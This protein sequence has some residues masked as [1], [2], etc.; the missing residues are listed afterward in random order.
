[1]GYDHPAPR[2]EAA[3]DQLQRGPRLAYDRSIQLLAL[4]AGL[5][6]TLT[7]L[8]ILWL[9]DYTPKVQWTLSTLIVGCTLLCLSVL[10]QRIVFPFQTLSNLLA[11]L[12]EGDYSLR[13]R[14]A[15]RD[16]VLGEVLHEINTLGE[17]LL[18]QRRVSL[19]AAALLQA[20]MRQ[21]QVAIFTFDQDDRLSLAN[22]AGGLL[23]GHPVE[24]LREQSAISLGLATCLAV[25]DGR[26]QTMPLDFPGRTG[27]RW[28]VRCTSFRQDGRL[29]RLLVL[30][31]LSQPLREEERV[32]W[33]RLIRVLGHELN[34]SLAPIH[35]IADSLVTL[36]NRAEEQRA[37]DWREDLTGGLSVIASRAE[38]LGRFMA[39]YSQL[40][41]LPPP[42]TCWLELGNLI[43][44][45]ASLETRL[46]VE[47]QPGPAIGLEVDGDQI[48]QLLINLVR[49]GVDAAR[50]TGGSV[51][52]RWQVASDQDETAV[53]IFVE[54]EGL[55]L[56]NTANLFVPFFTTKP[57]G[58]GIGLALSRQIAEAHHGTLTLQN[59]ADRRGCAACLRLPVSAREKG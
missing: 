48:E 51:S 38:V 6:G 46:A 43:N 19:E 45:V 4:L 52:L 2:R 36:I 59:R 58:S 49:N 57:D 29:H 32:A 27:S 31:D 47:V 40:A 10:R 50:S 25:P 39:S 33:Q 53:E 22:A 35:S 3:L 30:T 16:D 42:Q 44:R 55:G 23:L 21:I 15:R 5:P 20:V 11:A 1:M 41:R 13:A 56:A 34:N 24:Q 7:A 26:A 18:S 8:L 54:D 37:P 9:G 12:R 17:T 14:Q 28:G